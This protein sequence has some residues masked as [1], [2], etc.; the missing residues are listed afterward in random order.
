MKASVLIINN[1]AIGINLLTY[2]LH[3][4]DSIA[5]SK[6]KGESALTWR[7]LLGFEGLTIVMA[8]PHLI[9]VFSQSALQV[10]KTVLV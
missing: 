2:V 7:S 10:G 5:N 4:T 3:D 9:Q 6:G 8:N 1:L